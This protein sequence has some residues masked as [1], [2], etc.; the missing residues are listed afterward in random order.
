MK[1]NKS[2]FLVCIMA[3]LSIACGKKGNGAKGA[4]DLGSVD[5]ITNNPAI[6]VEEVDFIQSFNNFEFD[7]ETSLETFSVSRGSEK[8]EYTDSD[9]IKFDLLWSKKTR[10]FLA[11]HFGRDRSEMS[12]D[13]ADQLCE[14]RVRIVRDGENKVA[15]LESALSHCSIEGDAPAQVQLRSFIP[16]TIGHKYKLALKYKMKSFQDMT[17]KSYRNLVVHFGGKRQKYDPVFEEYVEIEFEIIATSKFSKLIFID[18]GKADGHGVLIDDIKIKDLGEVDN[19]GACLENYKLN[20]KGFKKCVRGEL[21]SDIACSFESS[22]D[23]I[24]KFKKG[25]NVTNQRADTSNIF[26]VEAPRRGN[27]N[28]LS[29]GLGGRAN[30]SCAIENTPALF[31]VFGK[32]LSL[33]EISWNNV[34]MSNYL[35]VAEVR[36]KLLNCLDDSLNKT[37]K[38]GRVGTL[39]FFE[40]EFIQDDKGRSYEGCKMSSVTIKDVTPNG[41][42]YDGFD[43]NSFEFF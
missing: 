3:T 41:P 28:F 30:I 17:D 35:E 34:S 24:V 38:L 25:K 20:S 39:E 21:P 26:T 43:I 16:T 5:N 29:L 23:A 27:I 31:N 33:R 6:S 2:L 32:T 1:P 22:A 42:S 19:Y 18:N 14:P 37:I 7:G 36:I 8:I 13:L 4:T 11:D 12:H 15:E 40:Y 10:N 9:K